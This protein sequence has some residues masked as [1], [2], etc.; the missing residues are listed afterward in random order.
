MSNEST[1]N[2]PVV[3]NT[4]MPIDNP[5]AVRVQIRHKNDRA[6]H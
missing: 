2:L 6:A 1:T 4:P 5:P 3:P